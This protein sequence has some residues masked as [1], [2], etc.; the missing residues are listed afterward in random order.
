MASPPGDHGS[1]LDHVVVGE[2][3]VGGQELVGPDHEDGLRHEIEFPEQCGHRTRAGD[4]DL[5]SWLAQVDLHDA[6]SEATE[7]TVARIIPMTITQMTI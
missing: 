5:P 3:L 4:L 7:A 1:E 6:K 2:T